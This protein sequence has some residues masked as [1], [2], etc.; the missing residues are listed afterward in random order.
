MVARKAI[1][2]GVTMKPSAAD[3]Y[4]PLGWPQASAN[5]L[6]QLFFRLAVVTLFVG[7][8][9]YLI[10]LRV[11]VPEQ[12]VRTIA[13]LAGMAL[14]GIAGVLT[15]RGHAWLGVRFLALG[16]WLLV[17]VPSF[18]LGGVHTP[19]IIAYP[20][21]LLLMAWLFPPVVSRMA[22]VL[23]IVALGLMG[24]GE[25]QG[26]LPQQPPTP[27]A[28]FVTSQMLMLGLTAIMASF[29]VGAYRRQWWALQVSNAQAV[30]RSAELAQREQELAE[31]H[32]RAQSIFDNN[33]DVL[34][35]SR[36]S[37]GCITDVNAAALRVFGYTREEV[38]GKT[39]LALGVW[40]QPQDRQRLVESLRL[41]GYCEGLEA[42]FRVRDGSTFVAALTAVITRLKGEPSVI[43]TVRDISARVRTQEQLRASE[44]LLRSTLE[45]ID[46]GVLMVDAHDQVLS[47]NQ[48]FLQLWSCNS[49][50]ELR[51]FRTLVAQ[52][53]EQLLEA[54][55]GLAA[56][57]QASTQAQ[58]CSGVL[59]FADGRAWTWFTRPLD[60]PVP[61]RIWC[62]GDISAQEQA[63][64][65]LQARERYQRALLDNFPFLVW[66][67]DRDS[68]FLAVNQTL[69]KAC[70]VGDPHAMAGM[71]DL[72]IACPELAHAYREDDRT[73]LASGQPRHVEE[74]I[75]I[76]GVRSWHETYKSPVL[77]DGQ[78]I[79]TVGFARDISTRKHLLD[80][81]EQSQALLRRILR[82]LPD[83]V[84]LKNP[85]GVY[86]ACNQRFEAFFGQSEAHIVGKTDYDFVD[87]ALADFFRENDRLAIVNGGARSNEEWVRFAHDGHSELLETTKTPIFTDEGALIGVL[88]VGHD[89]TQ[90]RAAED[91]LRLSASVYS[92]AREAIVIT[93][94]QGLMVDVNAAFTRITGY[95]RDQALGQPLALL[96]SGRQGHMPHEG[97]WLAL[98]EQ[99]YWEGEVWM[100]RRSGE[101]FAVLESASAV[102]DPQG[103]I[104][105]FVAMFSDITAQKQNQRRLERIAHYDA[106]TDLPNRVLFSDRL[107]QSMASALRHQR[108]MALV[109]MDLDGFKAVNDL[110]G[111]AAGDQLLVSLA[112]RMRQLVREGDTVA[113]LGGDEF[114]A[115]LVDLA[116]VAAALSLLERLLQVV[117]TPVPWGDGP[118]LQVSASLGVAFYPDANIP[119]PQALMELADTAMYRAKMA[120]KNRYALATPVPAD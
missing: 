117:S 37:D 64:R 10:L 33:P 61:G 41:R 67:K 60:G 13:P 4:A 15:W 63:Q 88:G 54:A 91:A 12:T 25:T 40:A 27:P 46:N 20:V 97:M 19:V 76:G 21:L 39:T 29:V 101:V 104:A 74:M 92:H 110:Y 106:L 6:S 100:R 82:A 69:A 84:W 102:R 47:C 94:A 109:F 118:G 86:L 78:V 68:R 99:G 114:V 1:G 5:D 72:D 17:T 93:D 79:G 28:L 31:A 81:L 35:I 105:H 116:S 119:T 85:E 55:Q 115:V 49:N 90:R 120:G 42:E 11:L 95:T 80:Q 36:L 107:Q 62:V 103:T 34:M 58:A 7:C 108:P 77:L 2:E 26:W 96:S 44:S 83:L 75:E 32:D 51:P 57:D 43:N 65:A 50:A 87:T 71:S 52:H 9:V 112:A 59:H 23:S 73:V 111:H 14:S 30:K 3:R 48:R 98:C 16:V 18:F 24:L 38:I 53:G 45:S 56:I 89:V 8:L 70:G 113:R 66:L 22:L